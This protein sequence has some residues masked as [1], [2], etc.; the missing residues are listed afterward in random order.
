VT[1]WFFHFWAGLIFWMGYMPEG[2]NP[3][4]YNF[5]ANGASAAAN[6][7]MLAVVLAILFKTARPLFMPKIYA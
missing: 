7:I 6:A 3:Y 2:V 5:I 4:L 1:R